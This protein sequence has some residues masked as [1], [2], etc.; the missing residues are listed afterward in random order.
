MK[1]IRYE[2]KN[3]IKTSI[4]TFQASD[5]EVRIKIDTIQLKYYIVKEDSGQLFI[6]GKGKSVQEI[7]RLA[8]E[9]LQFHGVDFEDEIR[10]NKKEIR[11]TLKGL[12]INYDF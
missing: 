11:K 2:N 9:S 6:H 10:E 3:G 5:Y 4:R 8:K 1:R 7:Q 12:G